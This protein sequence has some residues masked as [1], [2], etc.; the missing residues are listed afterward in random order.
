[1]KIHSFAAATIIVSTLLNTS[2]IDAATAALKLRTETQSNKSTRSEH[3]RVVHFTAESQA[4]VLETLENLNA[5]I[6]SYLPDSALLVTLPQPDLPALKTMTTS[7]WTPYQAVSPELRFISPEQATSFYDGVPVILG[8]ASPTALDLVAAKLS[9]RGAII[10]WH[11]T[12]TAIA[13]LGIRIPTAHL[14]DVRSE[15]DALTDLVWADVQAPLRA[16]NSRT[17]WRSQSGV[18][19]ETPIFDHDLNGE[20]QIIAIA[21]SG[22]DIDNCFFVDLIN[23]LP[24][25]NG[26]DSSDI[27][28]NHRKVLAVNFYWDEEWPNPSRFDWDTHGHGS[29]VSGTAAGDANSDGL[30]QDFD[31]MAPAA[32]LIMQDGGFTPDDC[33]DFPG[34]GCPVY[35]WEPMLQQAYDQGARIHSNSYGDEEEILPH[36]RYTERTADMDRF[37]W[38]NKDFVIVAAAGNAGPGEGSVISPAT[39]KNV[40][41][42]GATWHTQFE[43]Q[44]LADFSSW[45][46]VQ[47]GRIK[48]DILAPGRNIISAG[49]DFDSES[50]NCTGNQFSGTSMATPAV[51][52]FAALVRQYFQD[53]FYPSGHANSADSIDPSA[54][55][56]KA[57]LIASAVDLTSEGCAIVDPIPSIQQGWGMV[58]LNTALRFEESSFNLFVDDHREGFYQSS[59]APYTATLNVANRGPLKVVLVW[60]DPASSST[61]AFNLVNDLD[62]I[63]K[64]PDGVF[65]GNG[66]AGGISIAGSTADRHNNV[67]V[68]YL[69]E[70]SNGLWSVSVNPHSINIGPQD[71]AIVITGAATPAAPRN[72]VG[73]RRVGP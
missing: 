1:M 54:A 33:T 17:A 50:F 63:V 68:V 49:T 26:T 16:S 44:C 45:G 22:I 62:L 61:A 43:P 35:P 7:N 71:F 70:V 40:I 11:N 18:P 72:P 36:N 66:F 3:V 12:A 8:L 25:I 73:S 5:A 42:V 14:D 51:A 53:G 23:G 60:T 58:R 31:G 46:P 20:N 55:L 13:Q 34:F 24:A 27:N 9:S 47:D 29:H 6:V 67:E 65:A 15:I 48:P 32:R 41:A 57:T 28:P 4:S 64:G 56:V 19:G 38:N 69:P 59:D 39:A 52:G 21:D 2:T 10:A 37:I 30:Y